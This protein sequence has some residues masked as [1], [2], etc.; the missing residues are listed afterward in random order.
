MNKRI[1]FG[2]F[3][4]IVV[5]ILIITGF[6]HYWPENGDTTILILDIL[7]S[8]A[9]WAALS[10]DFFKPWIDLNS[11]QPRQVGSLGIRWT[12]TFLYAVAAV[13]VM[14]FG[15]VTDGSTL[16]SAF[17]QCGLQTVLFL[18]LISGMSW[19]FMAGDKVEEIARIEKGKLSGRASMKTALRKLSD[20]LAINTDIPLYLKNEIASLEESMRYITPSSNI[21]AQELEVEFN[22]VV[23][24]IRF[25]LSNFEMNEDAIKKNLLRLNRILESRK[26]V[27]N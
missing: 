20:E 5:E 6:L 24:N 15:G 17:G 23:D 19:S 4:F 3:S 8:T 10:V 7:V 21:E 25:A 11:E 1:F 14:Y 26:N 16:I 27:M 2:I 12:A 13:A 22:D 18:L 9:I